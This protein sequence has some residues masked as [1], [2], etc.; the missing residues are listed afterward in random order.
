MRRWLALVAYTALLYGLLPYG[1]ALGRA[2]QATD[3]GRASLGWGAIV[4]LVL[5]VAAIALRLR[6]RR[7]PR[8]AW[9]LAAATFVGYAVALFC[10]RAIRLERVHLPEYGIATW[11]AWRALVP[12]LGDRGA[13]YVA[14]AV[15]AALIGWGD[16]LVQAITPGRFYDLRDVLA[17]AAGATLG[18]FVLTLWR[19]GRDP[20][21]G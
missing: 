5:G 1:P 4:V 10:L 7:A 14:A 9:N 17:N 18:A 12:S 3:V 13:T 16:E 11:F 19:S 8:W 21:S 20:A 6:R 15:L 2:V